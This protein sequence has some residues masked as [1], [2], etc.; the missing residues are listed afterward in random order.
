[1]KIFISADIEGVTGTTVWEETTRGKEVYGEFQEQMTREVA[2]AC[3]GALAAGA[4]EVVVKDAHD[5]GRNIVGALLPEGVRLV[6]G[7]SRHPYLMMQELDASFDAAMMV[8]YHDCGGNGGNPLAH[9][10]RSVQ[11]REV[12]VNGMR[13]SEFHINA[14]TAALEGVPVAYLSGDRAICEAAEELLPGIVTTAVKEGRGGATIG[15]HP[16]EAVRRIRRG[17]EAALT[18]GRLPRVPELPEFFEVGIVFNDFR[19]AH[20]ASYYPGARLAAPGAILFET[21]SWFDVLRLLLFV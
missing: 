14:F 2:A 3:E 1:M 10:L 4:S 7:W 15:I 20:R 6:R 19:E 17:A 9:T 12:T 16:G 8:G 21:E 11:Y 18:G 5:T 13:V